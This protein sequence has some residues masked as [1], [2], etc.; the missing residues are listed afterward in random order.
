ML[1]P[2]RQDWIFA[3]SEALMVLDNAL[4]HEP[5]AD[6]RRMWALVGALDERV[7]AYLRAQDSRGH[8]AP[9]CMTCGFAPVWAL[10]TLDG[11]LAR[12]RALAQ[13]AHTCA[14]G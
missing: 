3:V 4:D 7:D 8:H 12:V 2:T 10:P 1:D 14:C 11:A 6:D 5:F 13:G 9:Y